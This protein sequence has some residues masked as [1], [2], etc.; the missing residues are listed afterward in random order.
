M[1]ISTRYWPL[2]AAT[3][4]L[5]AAIT[6]PS[7][8]QN[9]S[10]PHASQSPAAKL[11]AKP[12]TTPA[13]PETPAQIELLET[14]IRFE[15][16]G[17]SRKEVHTRVRINSELGARQFS[18]LNFNFNRAYEKV[19]IPQVHITHNSGGS[20]DILPSAITDQPDPVVG[21]VPAYQDVR[22]KSIRILGLEPA[23]ILEYRVI[24][25]TT[26]PALSPDFWLD[27][28]FDRTGVV[29]KEIF[30]LDLPAQRFTSRSGSSADAGQIR[31]SSQTPEA[32]KTETGS[33]DDTRLVYRWNIA[34][35]DLPKSANDPA[36]GDSDV[37]L[38]T[39]SSWSQLQQRMQ[40]ALQPHA[41]PELWT[42]AA[43]AMKTPPRDQTAPEAA[44]YNFVSTKIRTVDLPLDLGRFGKRHYSEILSSGF[45]SPEDKISLF[46]AL[47]ARTKPV[48]TL[49]VSAADAPEKQLPRPSV[50][51]QI[52]VAIDEGKHTIYLDP[53]LEV[54]PWGVIRPDLRGKK[55][56][57]LGANCG[58]EVCWKTI[59]GELPFSSTQR[60][61]VDATIAPDGTLDAKVKYTMRGDNELLLRI[62]FHQ[63]PRDKWKDVAQLM[64][65]SDGFRGKILSAS[66]SD[67]L[68]TKNAFT[69]EYEISQPKFVDWSKKP[70]RIAAPLPV[71]TVPDLPGKMGGSDKPI[72]IDLGMPLD[73]DTHVTL[74]LPAG[75]SVE[76]PTGTVVDRDYATFV[77]R[78]ETDSGTVT[79]N[80]HINFLRRQ[81]AV[82]RTPDYAAFLHAVQTDQSQLLTLTRPDATPQPTTEANTH[83]S[84]P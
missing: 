47:A 81:V 44:Y 79:A 62:A 2:L 55:A 31:I 3:A 41:S 57:E 73:V 75:T 58:G 84:K 46:T 25:I 28:N 68:A 53:D 54:A 5:F 26:H 78:Y 29:T 16:N 12:D 64:S 4:L 65:L 13:I 10:A 77:S 37:V 52:I 17:D 9:P 18:H 60:V 63:T 50:F 34:A 15:S 27:H 39:F 36:A 83:P 66:A 59:S 33:G 61:N 42:Q 40:S 56:L 8:A 1:S 82:D 38:T 11:E 48:K 24:T 80:R 69:V 74:H 71:L 72:P 70:V 43:T 45:G 76:L 7:R 67:P 32:S 19:E 49:L 21:D 23:D 14:K 22:I 20:A 6:L 35:A 51:S 30:E